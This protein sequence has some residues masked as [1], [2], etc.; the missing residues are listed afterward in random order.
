M[1][2]RIDSLIEPRCTGMCGALAISSPAASNSAQ[3]KSKP[4]LDVDGVRRVL[5]TQAHLFRDV[6]EQIVEDLEHDRVG[7]RAERHGR[8]P[9]HEL[10]AAPGCPQRVTDAR[11]PGSTTMVAL[12]CGDDGRSVD[13]MRRHSRLSP[14][15]RRAGAPAGRLVRRRDSTSASRAGARC[16]VRGRAPAV[17]RARFRRALG[18]PLAGADAFHRTRP[19]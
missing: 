12:R 5:Q 18:E 13:R 6:H 19:R 3:L 14:S 15:N 4:L 11:Q 17:R 1:T 9:R 16:A 10:G 2:V 7:V 8:R